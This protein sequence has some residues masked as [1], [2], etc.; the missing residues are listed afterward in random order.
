[1][2]NSPKVITI[3]LGGG[4]GTRLFP[5]TLK[6]AKPAVPIGGKYRLIDIPL[7][8]SINSGFRWIYVL[9]QYASESLIGH[10]HDTFIFDPFARGRIQILAAQ[11]TYQS[12]HWYKGTADAVR[13]HMPRFR[14]QR[15]DQYLILSGDHLY[16]MDYGKLVKFHQDG[17]WDVS[18]CF[19][20][21]SKSMAH[22]FGIMKL[23]TECEVTEFV[24]KPEDP[25]VIENL[26]MDERVREQ[27]MFDDKDRCLACS[28]GIYVF[29]P[30][31]LEYYMEDDKELIDF[32]KDIIPRAIEKFKVGGYLFK[33]YWADIGTI[34][35]YYKASLELTMPSSFSFSHS[36]FPIYT[37]RRYLSAS[38]ILSAEIHSSLI[39]EGVIIE[40]S[41]ISRSI[42][43][44]RSFIGPGT[45]VS[46]S[47]LMGND[48][49]ET[50]KAEKD[51]RPLGIGQGTTLRGVIVDKNVM[52]GSGCCLVNEA[53]YENYDDEHLYIRDGIIIVP[54]DAIIPSGTM[55]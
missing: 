19:I 7:S 45:E 43:G 51:H 48:Y 47:I 32:G 29:S 22:Q 54:K 26:V 30:S 9:T 33:G 20:P 25:D 5:L 24:E 42:I 37:H 34:R 28:M 11:Q 16:R 12:S 17:G 14:A 23:G 49:F 8:N 13:Q 52:I 31:V 3:V 4:K 36:N 55:I 53:K 18:I 35:S 2:E 46:D 50:E 1:M 10:I 21:M 44:I 41:K 27:F 39:S 38:K 15:P 6:R 40:E